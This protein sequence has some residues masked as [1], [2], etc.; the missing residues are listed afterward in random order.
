VRNPEREL[1]FRAGLLAAIAVLAFA[2]LAV[3][4]PP[5]DMGTT[6][7]ARN[8]CNEGD[9]AACI[10]AGWLQWSGC[11]TGWRDR[12]GAGASFQRGMTEVTATQLAAWHDGCTAGD[13]RACVNLGLTKSYR[14]AHGSDRSEGEAALER[15]CELR[16]GIGCALLG[17]ADAN[18]DTPLKRERVAALLQQACDLEEPSG[19]LELGRLY[20]D[21]EIVPLNKAGAARLFERAC[22]MKD[23]EGCG[24][25][26]ALYQ[27][28]DGVPREERKAIQLYEMACEGGASGC[29]NLQ[30]MAESGCAAASLAVAR[31]LAKRENG[32]LGPETAK[33]YQAACDAGSGEACLEL[34]DAYAAQGGTAREQSAALRQ[35]ACTLGWRD[36][37]KDDPRE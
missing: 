7:E 30:R 14:R 23:A 32:R 9:G 5:C 29:E 4:E 8:A 37:C 10:R 15:G 22:A 12:A 34:A 19:C 31:F 33:H 35:R 24:A 26:A 21:G 28:G 36:A 13:G 17:H 2:G 3:A 25:L 1:A 16:N 6:R 11:E 27:L 20:F 18:S